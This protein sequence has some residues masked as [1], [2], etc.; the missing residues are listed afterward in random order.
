[1]AHGLFLSDCLFSS[2]CLF[3][4]GRL[5]LSGFEIGLKRRAQFGVLMGFRGRSG[6][7]GNILKAAIDDRFNRVEFRLRPIARCIAITPF[8]EGPLAAWP[9]R[10]AVAL[11]RPLATATRIAIARTAV[12]A[13][14]TIVAVTLTGSAIGGAALARFSRCSGAFA[15]AVV[16]A[17]WM[18]AAAARAAL[19]AVALIVAAIALLARLRRAFDRSLA[20][21]SGW[22]RGAARLGFARMRRVRRS[23]RSG[24]PRSAPAAAAAPTMRLI[25]ARCALRR[26]AA[27]WG[28]VG[29]GGS[30]LGGGPRLG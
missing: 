27:W 10:A 22:Y 23:R 9:A 28:R 29:G 12:L 2:G 26:G 6:F 24:G 19:V 11:T 3:L 13:I 14:A 20:R 4:I 7:H 5:G 1:M 25:T 21:R 15:R 18:T 8:A 16:A 30:W 17:P